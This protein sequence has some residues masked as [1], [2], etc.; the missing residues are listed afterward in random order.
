MQQVH[1]VDWKHVASVALAVAIIGC[2]IAASYADSGGE[3]PLHITAATLTT[4][5]LV[6]GL[7][8]KQLFGRSTPPD[9]PTIVLPEPPPPAP[10]A[11]PT[12]GGGS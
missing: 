5:L 7:I 11:P 10:P 12:Q 3:L 1:N 2:Q 8:S 6:F 4:A 9:M